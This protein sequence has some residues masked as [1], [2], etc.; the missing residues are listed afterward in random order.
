MPI[1]KR[2]GIRHHLIDVCNISDVYSSGQFFEQALQ[3]SQDIVSRGKIPL[4]VGGTWFY[5]NFL[6]HGKPTA[7]KADIFIENEVTQSVFIR[8]SLLLQQTTCFHSHLT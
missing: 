5:L 6:L 1:E 2:K 7:P 8:F 3:I 4:I